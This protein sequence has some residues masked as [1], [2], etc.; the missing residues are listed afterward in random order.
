MSKGKLKAETWQGARI[1][2][3]A[4]QNM[5]PVQTSSCSCAS[6]SGRNILHQRC[7]S[8]LYPAM[9]G[10]LFHSMLVLNVVIECP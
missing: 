4:C 10:L 2:A 3:C 5:L 7:V 8:A 1:N 9:A 6:V